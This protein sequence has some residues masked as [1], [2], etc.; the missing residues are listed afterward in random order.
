MAQG[1]ESIDAKDSMGS[2]FL[3]LSAMNGRNMSTTT[4]WKNVLEALLA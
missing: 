1:E 3:L 2:L 4:I